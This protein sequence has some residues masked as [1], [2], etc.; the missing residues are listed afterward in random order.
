MGLL[1]SLGNLTSGGLL[2]GGL[3]DDTD[4]NG[5]SHVS[6]GEATER[7]VGGEDLDDHGLLGD[8]LD[9]SGITSLN[10]W[11][12]V[13]GGLTG[14]L[15]DLGAD[16][17]ELA[18]N[19]GGVAIE[20]GCVAVLD[21]TGVVENDDLGNEH[22]GILGGVVLGVRADVASLDVLDGQVLDVETNVVTGGGLLD[23]LVVH[24]DGLDFGNG[25]R[26]SKES[27]DTRLDDTSLNSQHVR[28]VRFRYL[29]SCRHPEAEDGLTWSRA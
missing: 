19:V 2:A 28:Q 6:D 16:L 5:L 15:V 17:G 21:L 4:G 26:R 9:H 29:R 12:L 18:G 27:M 7:G 23:L 14:T 13:F 8:K 25:I 11:W 1:S 24:L 22:L 10:A 20:D 3:L